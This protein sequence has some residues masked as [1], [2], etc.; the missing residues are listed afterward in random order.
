MT[1][2]TLR[3]D[4]L[5]HQFEENPRRHFVP[6]ANAF[7][8]AGNA[9]RAVELCRT[10]LPQLP[11]HVS[12]HVVLAGALR[13]LGAADEARAE[14][15]RVLALDAE[16]LVAVRAL[17]DLAAERG[18]AMEARGWYARL[19]EL[20]PRDASA[21][22]RLEELTQIAAVP[23]T[24]PYAAVTGDELDER[25]EEIAAT[26]LPSAE[27]DDMLAEEFTAGFFASVLDEPAAFDTPSDPASRFAPPSHGDTADTSLA[28][29][30]LP[31][32]DELHATLTSG[33]DVGGS[34]RDLLAVDAA[35]AVDAVDAIDADAP[36]ADADEVTL[37]WELEP[38][39][40][41][42]AVT[43]EV[44]SPAQPVAAPFAE[45]AWEPD[46]PRTATPSGSPIMAEFPED[47]AAAGD[48]ASAPVPAFVTETMAD[49]YLRQGFR[50][51]ALAVYRQL[52]AACP[53]DARLQARVE[54]LARPASLTPD[55]SLPAVDTPDASAD[56]AIAV[57]AERTDDA[58]PPFAAAHV[59]ADAG[60][61]PERAAS[62][63]RDGADASVDPADGFDTGWTAPSIGVSS[64]GMVEGVAGVAD[65]TWALATPTVSGPTVSAWLSGLVA[66]ADEP[67]VEYGAADD[68]APT[69]AGSVS[70]SA[71]EP[72]AEAQDASPDV[73]VPELPE[74]S[75]SDAP[76]VA[77]AEASPLID[78]AGAP[79][80][81]DETSGWQ[82]WDSSLAF[83]VRLDPHDAT[84][85]TDVA[86]V[87]TPT[88]DL[89]PLAPAGAGV[90][91][92]G[93]VALQPDEIAGAVSDAD[94]EARA[95]DDPFAW[96]DEATPPSV[97]AATGDAFSLDALFARP[98]SAADEAA[99]DTL[100]ATTL[101]VA[102]AEPAD[103]ALDE[104]TAADEAGIGGLLR[105]TPAASP[106]LAATP[107]PLRGGSFSFEQFFRPTPAAGSAPAPG[108]GTSSGGT[109]PA[110]AARERDEDLD[111]FHRWLAGL[112][113][114]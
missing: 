87:P 42:H 18:N 54:E 29:D 88:V 102:G 69:V 82:T 114:S 33:W 97:P 39:D 107:E 14:Y 80:S 19:V 64:S 70:A 83:D 72:T 75:T 113:D 16:N 26:P 34:D 90:A 104:A 95:W 43:P 5:Q 21:T 46:A 44:P 66:G 111:E 61:E 25:Q 108:V 24:P 93:D 53:D 84:A 30:A 37:E 20:D 32:A 50:A 96:D 112:S 109:P 22:T 85:P 48:R 28:G 4:H 17:G 60:I 41:H 11:G 92:A 58:T 62:G 94:P 67:V 45:L 8:Q 98:A 110:P 23:A 1:S 78:D 15:E 99:A 81:A 91:P 51:E 35:D 40:A 105:S 47:E 52:L 7:L 13:A 31:G 2:R 76:D 59:D 74:D 9:H 77:V 68:V 56:D 63:E 27:R 57:V 38:A 49:L 86:G 71:P 36:S 12:G 73:G 89:E 10:F 103:R 79:P 100:A 6:L 101:G 106:V 55:M 3:F 65:D